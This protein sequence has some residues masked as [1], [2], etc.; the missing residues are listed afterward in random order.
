MAMRKKIHRR[1]FLE[2]AGGALAGALGLPH[3]VSASV[4]G[5][6]AGAAP[7]ERVTVGC[8]GVG[9]RGR[10]V[11]RNF[12]AEG[13][14]RVVAVC[15]VKRRELEYAQDF[16][17]KHYGGRGC[18]A[19]R[20]SRELLARD[21]VDAV[22]IATPDH[23]H[24][25]HALAAAGAGKD[26]YLEKPLGL[27]LAEDQALRAA[28]RRRGTVFQFGTQQRSDLRFRLACELVRN[29]RIG[30]LRSINVWSPASRAGG[31]T[32]P[33]PVPE[34]LDYDTWLGP[35]PFVP[36][37]EH[38]CTNVFPGSRDPFKIWPFISDYCLGWVA[39]W[40]VHPLD[41]ALW[42]GGEHVTG[43]VEIEGTGTFPAEG[44]C[45]TAT[46]WKIAVRY[47][48]LTID[49]RAEP[50]PHPWQSRYGATEAHG[51]AFEGTG[52]WVVVDRSRLNAHPRALLRSTIGPGEVRLYESINHV[53]NFL[54]CV[55]SRRETICPIGAAMA[56]DTLCQLCAI[57]LRLERRL[58]WDDKSERFVNDDE[59]NRMLARAMRSP[60][61]L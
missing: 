54:D 33:A 48:G 23:W 20:D 36:Y 19:C 31:S 35:A 41:I 32:R 58:Q 52:G 18:A 34:Y 21:D 26:I 30:E 4:L 61:H 46:D 14:A 16:V 12:L 2:Q 8:I 42:G 53:G 39:G 15:D 25:L 57:A 59:A 1:A 27:S 56:V 5:R 13:G 7:S 38:R 24:V 50:A 37:T 43:P 49:F 6:G 45:D 10:Q 11:M 3:I 51:T 17:N 22:L 60:W 44:A 29:G 47:A 40:G 28:V 9:D 55:R